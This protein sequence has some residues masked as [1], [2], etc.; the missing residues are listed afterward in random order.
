[1]LASPA[2]AATFLVC[3]AINLAD[4]VMAP[5]VVPAASLFKDEG[6]ADDP[7]RVYTRDFWQLRLETVLAVSIPPLQECARVPV[8]ITSDS[9]VRA[10]GAGDNRV[11]VYA[12]SNNLLDERMPSE[13]LLTLRGRVLDNVP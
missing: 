3:R 1:M 2:G 5:L 9:S 7:L 4:P 6:R 10:V 13:D 12:G 11:F 8:R